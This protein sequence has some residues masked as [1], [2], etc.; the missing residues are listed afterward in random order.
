VD[1]RAD[2]H[3]AGTDDVV[4]DAE[5]AVPG[6]AAGRR[7]WVTGVAAAMLVAAAGGA[8]FGLGRAVGDSGDE[9]RSA[10]GAHGRAGRGRVALA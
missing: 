2:R 1:G 9:L 5:A 8:G 10:A 6:R 4:I 7:R 3:V